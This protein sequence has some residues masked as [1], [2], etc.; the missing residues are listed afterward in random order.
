MYSDYLIY[1]IIA[2]VYMFI[3]LLMFE[4]A[5]ASIKPLRDVNEDRDGKYPAFRRW[6][7]YKWKKWRFYFGAVTFM[8]IRFILSICIVIFC[9]IF[10]R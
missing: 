4:W 5:W 2:G 3:G 10:V 6:D 7:A 8:P 9:Y 1:Y